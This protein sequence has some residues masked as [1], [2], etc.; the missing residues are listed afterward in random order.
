[1]EYYT[2]NNRALDAEA[3]AKS[4]WKFF[5]LGSWSRA[6]HDEMQEGRKESRK[7]LLEITFV[8]V[9]KGKKSGKN[10]I[11]SDEG[12]DISSTSSAGSTS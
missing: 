7:P 12:V 3:K 5:N 2:D 6:V 11:F 10:S 8:L 4:P 1:M 9:C